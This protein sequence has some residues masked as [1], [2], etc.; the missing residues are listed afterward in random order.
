[1]ALS[2]TDDPVLLGTLGALERGG[3][4]AEIWDEDW[5]VAGM[6]DDYVRA[7]THGDPEVELGVGLAALSDETMA[8]RGRWPGGPVIESLAEAWQRAIGYYA[9]TGADV[10]ALRAGSA[11]G[12]AALFRDVTPVPMPSLWI[13]RVQIRFGT[14]FIH[15][16]VCCVRLNREDGTFAG[17][18]S[19][20]KPALRGAVLAM[21]ALGDERLFERQLRLTRPTRQPAAIL[22]ADLE[23]STALSRRM[24]AADY[25]AL[26][27]RLIHRIDTCVVE[28][29][30]IV[31]KH[32]G[33]GVTAFFLAGDAGSESAAAAA[34]IRVAR[35]LP[36]HARA[37]AGRSGLDHDDVV[38]RFGLHFGATLTVGQLLT[39][40]RADVT[41]IGDEVNETARIEACATGGRAL[42]S[43]AL[44]E[45]LDL[46]DARTLDLARPSF[47]AL[48]DLATVTDKARRDALALSVCEV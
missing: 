41:A 36:G 29:G 31:G 2:A 5:R 35:E 39:A 17:V 34:A 40:G 38:L 44:I 7:A 6:T 10:E 45:R 14:G 22:F 24:S 16:D 15:N 47:A 19:V 4:A 30:G 3:F 32:A 11:P 37:A 46:G 13:E 26:L 9:S 18:A 21:L 33:D 43:K 23:G 8:V 1:M 12:L 27:R 48:E 20:L 28:A 25:F 42:A